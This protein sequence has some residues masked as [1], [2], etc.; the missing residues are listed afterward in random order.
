MVELS[1]RILSGVQFALRRRAASRRAGEPANREPRTVNR[2]MIDH[3]HRH[4][5][6]THAGRANLTEVVAAGLAVCSLDKGSALA[7][8]NA[9]ADR[10]GEVFVVASLPLCSR[11]L[12]APVGATVRALCWWR[13]AGLFAE[14]VGGGPQDRSKNLL[15]RRAPAVE[16]G[17]WPA[18]RPALLRPVGT[19]ASAVP[20]AAIVSQDR[21][22][23]VWR[24]P[25][26]QR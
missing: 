15:V 6:K 24:C 23:R 18:R 20:V 21:P 5:M 26:R 4:A 10:R 13:A 8:S 12:L 25:A 7:T 17:C 11:I 14:H 22:I 19:R 9:R 2:E 16:E 1:L 3:R